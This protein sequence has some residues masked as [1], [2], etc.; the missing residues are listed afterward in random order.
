M[1][2]ELADVLC[3]V[4]GEF[5]EIC[6]LNEWLFTG[7]GE[8][9]FTTEKYPEQMQM[10]LRIS[11]GLEYAIA[12]EE[13]VQKPFILS[14]EMGLVW[15]GEYV[16]VV[17]SM[18]EKQI[19]LMGPMF[20]SETSMK[21]ISD[22]LNKLNIS[23][24]L[25]LSCKEALQN[26]PIID[27]VAMRQYGRMLHLTITGETIGDK[28]F[29]YQ[30]NTIEGQKVEELHFTDYEMALS[31]DNM[32]LKCVRE[33]NIN[34][35]EFLDKE[36]QYAKP[37]TFDLQDPTREAKD[38]VIRLAVLCCRAAIEGGL[39]IA[40]SKNIE[41]NTIRDVE[42]CENVSDLARISENALREYI[43]KVHDINANPGISKPIRDCCAYIQAHI[44]DDLDLSNIAKNIGYTEY[45]LSRKFRNEMGIKIM[46]YIRN[47]RIEYAKIWL[48]SSGISIQEISERLRFNS[49]NY[50]SKVFKEKEGVTPAEYRAKAL[51]GGDEK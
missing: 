48:I 8:L 44:V 37:I 36:I 41:R 20:N 3:L 19:V 26:I 18:S 17:R 32:I 24:S 46:D 28:D 43:E 42:M 10:F 7:Q 45:Y 12:L 27:V 38:N 25:K 13:D 47:K 1:G 22:R 6:G 23:V 11:G 29:I 40:E 33:G 2:V 30:N 21:K 15:V 34:Y 50:F 51:V 5:K 9:L 31:R 35:K 49:R 14:D 39:S 16:N 4:M